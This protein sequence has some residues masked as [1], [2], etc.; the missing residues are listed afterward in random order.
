MK[1]RNVLVCLGALSLCAACDFPPTDI[2]SPIANGPLTQDELRTFAELMS[3]ELGDEVAACLLREATRN[4]EK[5][6]DPQTLDQA[7]LALLPAD[8]WS[9]LI[10]DNKRIIL[11]QIVF[12]QAIPSCSRLRY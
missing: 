3:V 1:C 8:N 4:A 10:R 11:T 6:G 7:N 5:A 9:E 2:L 12:N